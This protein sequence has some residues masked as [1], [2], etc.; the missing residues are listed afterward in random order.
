V[1]QDGFST[2]AGEAT[3]EDGQERRVEVELEL[4]DEMTWTPSEDDIRAEVPARDLNRALGDRSRFFDGC[5][6][7]HL[8]GAEPGSL[9]LASITANVSSRGWIVGLSFD[10]EN[11][12]SNDALRTC[13]KRQLRSIKLP[14]FTGDYA[15]VKHQFRYSVP[16]APAPK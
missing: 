3:L 9:A 13:L 1:E 11:Y 10:D 6:H 12:T 8:T 7:N 5:Y 15:V 14:L 16:D 4:T 2:W